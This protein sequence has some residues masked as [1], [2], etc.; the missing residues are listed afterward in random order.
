[1]LDS[2]RKKLGV[3][4]AIIIKV[5]KVSEGFRLEGEFINL[6]D[7]QIHRSKSDNSFDDA[8]IGVELQNILSRLLSKG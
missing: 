4:N 8:A 7:G 1:M 2:L 6:E 3:S 5:I